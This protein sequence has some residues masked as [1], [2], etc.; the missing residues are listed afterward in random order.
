MKNAAETPAPSRRRQPTAARTQYRFFIPEPLLTLSY[1]WALEG[2]LPKKPPESAQNRPH[3]LFH[4]QK[5]EGHVV[6]L[7]RPPDEVPDVGQNPLGDLVQGPA[8]AGL[9]GGHEPLL[10]VGVHF[11]VHGL[12]EAVRVE[13]Q[14]VALPQE[15]L[16]GV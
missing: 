9:Q 11:R 12:R 3:G 7:L 4:P 16:P 10:P 5:Q 6:V 8:L 1:V 14:E 15:E 13:E 2:F